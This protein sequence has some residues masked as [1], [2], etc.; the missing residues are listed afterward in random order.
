MELHPLRRREAIAL[1]AAIAVAWGTS[2]PVTK[3]ILQDLPP[4]WTTVLRSSI[5]TATLFAITACRRNV[6]LPQ[7]GDI[8]VVLNIALLHMGCVLR[9]S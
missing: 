7:R 6:V 8:S 9:P 3:A 2:W 4:L 1:L 5:G